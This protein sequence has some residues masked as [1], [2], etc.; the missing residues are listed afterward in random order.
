MFYPKEAAAQCQILLLI[1]MDGQYRELQVNFKYKSLEFT[2]K[3]ISQCALRN[4]I[5][6]LKWLKKNKQT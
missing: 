3:Y 6:T 5:M 1:C 4:T 2:G